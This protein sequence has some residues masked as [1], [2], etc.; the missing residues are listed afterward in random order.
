MVF[1]RIHLNGTPASRL[2]DQYLAAGDAL[3]KAIDAVAAIDVNAR[4]YYPISA[5]AVYD[6]IKEHVARLNSLKAIRYEIYRICES[7]DE[8]GMK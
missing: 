2:F 8:Q 7:I 3:D 6:A 1:P 5:D 4:D